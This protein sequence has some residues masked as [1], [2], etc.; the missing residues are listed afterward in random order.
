MQMLEEENK[1][2][3]KVKRGVLL[4]KIVAVSEWYKNRK[5]LKK[6]DGIK[7]QS[8]NIAVYLRVGTHSQLYTPVRFISE[9]LGA[10]V[11]WIETEQ[12]VVITKQEA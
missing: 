6:S 9:E 5:Q 2:K 4:K 3:Q 10:S 8:Y 1:I 7:E 11:E 12:R